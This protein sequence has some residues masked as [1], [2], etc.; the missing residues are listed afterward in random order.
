M[1]G[2]ENKDQGDNSK[3]C[4]EMSPSTHFQCPMLNFTNYTTWAIQ[5]QIIL[6]ANTLGSD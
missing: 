6:E 1:T 2:K 4:E 5:M 3:I